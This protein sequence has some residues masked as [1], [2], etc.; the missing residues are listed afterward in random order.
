MFG[1]CLRGR[2]CCTAPPSR[3]ADNREGM[4]TSAKPIL[5]VCCRAPWHASSVAV[6]EPIRVEAPSSRA[7]MALLAEFAS[8]GKP[9]LV[10]L[11]GDRW[12]VLLNDSV[13]TP[14][15]DIL[16]AVEVWLTAW[17]TAE[18]TVHIGGK[19]HLLAARPRG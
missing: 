13:R 19:P 7:A 2:C 15:A 18:T 5:R 9:D 17:N 3:V 8:L 10:P 1:V 14:M 6:P 11:N 16:R 12:E 4:P